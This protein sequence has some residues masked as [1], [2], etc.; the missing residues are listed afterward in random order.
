MVRTE[1]ELSQPPFI[2][3]CQELLFEREQL[4]QV[5]DIKYFRMEYIEGLEQGRIL[6]NQ[7]VAGSIP[8]GGSRKSMGYS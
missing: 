1:P 8:A 3:K 4:P 6:R 2:L 5:V 7:E